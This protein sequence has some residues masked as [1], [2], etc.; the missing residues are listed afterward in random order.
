VG[1]ASKGERVT[2]ASRAHGKLA[3]MAT[4]ETRLGRITGRE[5]DV[6]GGGTVL[7]VRGVRYAEAP[8]GERRFRPPVRTGGWEG[9]LDATAFG[10]RSVQ[11]PPP[12]LLGGFGPGEVSEDCLFL[13]V[14][15]PAADGAGRPVLCWI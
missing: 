6:P 7:E 2:R 3:L 8:V 10:G 1:S 14:T 5:T 4:I 11:M 9:T 12:E 13:N 15:T